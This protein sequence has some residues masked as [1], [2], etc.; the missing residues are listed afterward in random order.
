MRK[1]VGQ[2]II[3]TTR[4]IARAVR[5]SCSIFLLFL[6]GGSATSEL[7]LSWPRKGVSACRPSVQQRH[8]NH[9]EGFSV[10][11]LTVLSPFHG[12]VLASA[13]PQTLPLPR[14]DRNHNGRLVCA[15]SYYRFPIILERFA[16]I[17]YSAGQARIEF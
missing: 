2:R 14:H 12:R 4:R 10:R 13:T 7:L 1:S 5:P 15:V 3:K 16:R 6:A 17:N 8:F 9:E 11:P